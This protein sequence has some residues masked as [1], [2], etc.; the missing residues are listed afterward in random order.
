MAWA[1]AERPNI[2]WIMAEDLSTELACYGHAAVK[3]PNLD[4]LAAQGARWL[5]IVDLEGAKNGVPTNLQALVKIREKI[6]CHIQFGGGVRKLDDITRIAIN[7]GAWNNAARV[8]L[9]EIILCSHGVDTFSRTAHKKY[10][11]G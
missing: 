10:S 7:A 4:G 6:K 2:V 1:Q 3:T 5:H 9:P 8:S 11:P